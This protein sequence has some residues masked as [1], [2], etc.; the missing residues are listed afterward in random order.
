MGDTITAYIVWAIQINTRSR[1]EMIQFHLRPQLITLD[2]KE[3]KNYAK[4]LGATE[5]QEVEILKPEHW[6]D[7]RD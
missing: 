6:E 5:I 1:S 2:P 3:A 7:G 4:G